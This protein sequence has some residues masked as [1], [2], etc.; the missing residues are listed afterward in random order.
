M[1]FFIFIFCFLIVYVE[2]E[3]HPISDYYALQNEETIKNALVKELDKVSSICLC[4][5]FIIYLKSHNIY[6]RWT[7]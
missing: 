2:V 1:K 7:D 4:K 5:L 3:S 6:R